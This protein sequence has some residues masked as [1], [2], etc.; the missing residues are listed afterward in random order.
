MKNEYFCDI[1]TWPAGQLY[2]GGRSN[3]HSSNYASK[4]AIVHPK[5]ENKV[6]GEKFSG[7]R[8]LDECRQ[9]DFV[10]NPHISII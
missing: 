9:E 10:H 2:G 1:Q 4:G 8:K 6:N 7:K 3:K 5:F